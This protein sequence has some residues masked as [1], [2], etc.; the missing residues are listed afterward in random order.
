MNLEQT[1]CLP[2]KSAPSWMRPWGYVLMTLGG[3]AFVASAVTECQASRNPTLGIIL[4][5]ACLNPL[6]FVGVPLGV[7]WRSPGQEI[8]SPC[9]Y[10]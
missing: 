7:Y 9:R 2:S 10:R 4:F 6:F 5:S 1:E 8:A 3:L